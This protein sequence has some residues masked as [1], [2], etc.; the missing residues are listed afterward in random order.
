MPF[1]EYHGNKI[2]K[3]CPGGFIQVHGT[4]GA[5]AAEE[6][7]HATCSSRPVARANRRRHRLPSAKATAPV[8]SEGHS[9]GCS[10]KL[11]M[12][13]GGT[14][15]DDDAAA[16]AALAVRAKLMKR[17][18]ILG[19]AVASHSSLFAPS[20]TASAPGPAAPA[21]VTTMPGTLASA[22]SPAPASKPAMSSL[23]KRPK[24]AMLSTPA[25]APA[26]STPHSSA[27]AVAVA[28]ARKRSQAEHEAAIFGMASCAQP[29]QAMQESDWARAC[30]KGVRSVY[31]DDDEAH[32]RAAATEAAADPKEATVEDDAGAQP[33]WHT[34]RVGNECLT[35]IDGTWCTVVVRSTV[36]AGY[37][38][39]RY[40]MAPIDA[41]L[42]ERT[43]T[44]EVGW[45]ALRRQRYTSAARLA[46]GICYLFPQGECK[47]GDLC[48]F[49][50]V[51]DDTGPND[52]AP[53]CCH[54][55]ASAATLK[56]TPTAAVK[57]QAQLSADAFLASMMPPPPPPGPAHPRL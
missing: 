16:A 12:K 49:A 55:T 42:C 41:S 2:I 30:G 8:Q 34:L 5:A 33:L 4:A 7:A 57:T 17:P 50:H 46:R 40:K 52:A 31:A 21:S 10:V 54:P 25:T 11:H 15:D 45:Q 19:G 24:P 13:R 43:G 6:C 29:R 1:T 48:P 32:G 51:A 38:T 22:S 47:R 56:A 44:F 53:P 37:E 35:R 3:M 36:H 26:A 18:Q 9:S 27:H 28:S 20:T 23:F 14:A 39:A